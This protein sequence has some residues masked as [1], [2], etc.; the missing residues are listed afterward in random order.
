MSRSLRSD[1][2][3]ANRKA[4]ERIIA[5]EAMLVDLKPAIKAIPG[6]KSNL[7]THAG[8]PIEWARMV[9]VQK[10]AIHQC[11]KGRRYH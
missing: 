6:Y 1:I 4:T 8:P 2:D 10:I 9:K 3:E 11:H 5:A 7:I